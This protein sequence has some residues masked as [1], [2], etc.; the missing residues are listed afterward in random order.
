[1]FLVFIFFRLE[2][3]FVSLLVVSNTGLTFNCFR[4]ST[5][6]VRILNLQLLFSL[7]PR[8]NVSFDYLLSTGKSGNVFAI[9]VLSELLCF[10]LILKVYI[11]M[12]VFVII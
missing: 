5:I 2:I 1:M 4:L 6:A 11:I 3:I 12:K 9:Q 10:C 8:L 7:L